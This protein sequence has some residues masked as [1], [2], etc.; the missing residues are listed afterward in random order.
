ML[1]LIDE[2]LPAG[3]LLE[4]GC[5]L[6]RYLLYA[7]ARG[8][9][10]IGIDFAI[11]PLKRVV[12][13]DPRALVAAADLSHM[14]FAP[15]TFDTI[16]CFGVLEHF[17]TGAAPQVKELAALLRPGGWLVVTVP[18]ANFLKRRRATAGGQDVVKAGAEL[19][20]GM[21]FYQHCFTRSEARALVSAGGLEI[22]EERR[23]SR[24]FWLLGGRSGRR[25]GVPQPPGASAKPAGPP[26][27]A[28]RLRGLLR[29]AAY[30]L[31]WAI[32]PD[33]TSHM[34]VVVGR[35]PA[36]ASPGS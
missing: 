29:D 36:S 31:Q 22:I 15:Q 2:R 11:D 19:P 32:P 6:G 13:H 35:K 3:H 12:A 24:L 4:A 20:D 8:H 25:K 14:P 9:R 17:E 27:A 7:V 5:G 16:L 1:D 23:V 33:L 30:W 21:R 34:I 28:G 10:A 18:Y 26:P